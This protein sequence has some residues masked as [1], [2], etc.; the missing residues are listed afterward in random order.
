MNLVS[1]IIPVYKVEKYLDRCVQSIIDQAYKNLEIILVDDGSPDKCPELCDEWAKK[2]NRVKVIHQENGGVCSARNAGINAASG[3]YITF[4]DSDDCVTNKYSEA[5]EYANSS[6]VEMVISNTFR[7]KHFNQNKNYVNLT[8]KDFYKIFQHDIPIS[9]WG[10]IVSRK[11]VLE[12]DLFFVSGSCGEDLEW[13][14]RTFCCAQSFSVWADSFYNYELTETSV[15]GNRKF[16]H[17]SSLVDNFEKIFKNIDSTNY[18]N[19]YKKRA[20]AAIIRNLYYNIAI[21]SR[22]SDED[23]LLV[24]NKLKEHHQLLICPYSVK[25]KVIY[26]VFKIFG[27]K[28]GLKIINKLIR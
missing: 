8:G 2:D 6:N 24:E 4:I 3:E 7:N 1:V 15:C 23:K 28:L 5:L 25:Y 18:K 16:K 22:Y 20:K 9:C 12:N 17:F 11:F 26:L 10:K 27:L 19:K 13:S 21:I 14:I